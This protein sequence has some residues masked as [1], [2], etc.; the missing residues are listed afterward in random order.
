MQALYEYDTLDSPPEAAFDRIADLAAHLFD[1]PM[2][3]VSLIDDDRQ[4]QKACL[5]FD[6]PEI[7]LSASFCT[8]TIQ[9][10]G[11]MVVE[12]APKTRA[13]PTTR[14]SPATLG[15]ASTPARPW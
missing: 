8:Y 2:A 11:A 13:L 12:D 6:T 1:A 3:V 7:D 4:W 15:F 5:G 10:S 14:S 9:S